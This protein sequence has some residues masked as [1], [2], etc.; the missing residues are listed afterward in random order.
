[1]VK[2]QKYTGR[3]H[4]PPFILD[5]IYNT[6]YIFFVYEDYQTGVAAHRVG[7]SADL[8][9]TLIARNLWSAPQSTLRN[10]A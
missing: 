9:G 10:Y 3:R 7:P 6:H 2:D 1:M 5:N 8:T 4:D